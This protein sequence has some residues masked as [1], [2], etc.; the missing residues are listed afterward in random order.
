MSGAGIWASAYKPMCKIKKK[1]KTLFNWNISSYSILLLRL[2]RKK[3]VHLDNNIHIQFEFML[4]GR[5]GSIK[6]DFPK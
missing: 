5:F 6:I 1:K 2:K 4:F 3:C